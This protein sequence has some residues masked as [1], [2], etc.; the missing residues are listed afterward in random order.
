MT[1]V[2]H[3]NGRLATDIEMRFTAS[4]Q[5]IASFTVVTNNGYKDKNSNSWI[6]KETTFWRASAFGKLAENLVE[7]GLG[8]GD[9]V[10]GFGSTFIRE[11]EL[12][13]GSGKGKSPEMSVRSLGPDLNFAPPRP[14]MDPEMDI[15]DVPF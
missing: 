13:D 1:L 10:V 8:K 3:F 7:S 2:S 15:E 9:A 12:K 11:Y 14:T 4:G 6:E 5:G